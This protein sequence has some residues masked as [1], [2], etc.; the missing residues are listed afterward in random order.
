[1][2]FRKYLGP[3]LLLL[4][5][6]SGASAQYNPWWKWARADTNAALG[7]SG[8]GSILAAK[9]GK[10]LWGYMTANQTVVNASV[11]GTWTIFEYDSNGVR[12]G[13]AA[14]GGKVDL[15]DAQADAAG[16]W[17]VLGRYY[18]S[19]VLPSTTLIRIN[20]ATN[21]DPDHFLLR[22]NAGSMFMS[23]FR[24]I[25]SSNN[26][27]SRA[28]TV[29]NNRIILAA[30]STDATY[31]RSVDLTTGNVTPLFRQGGTSTT[32]SVQA[33]AGGNIYLAGSCSTSDMDFNGTAQPSPRNVPHAYIVKYNASG[34]H[35]W[36][37]WIN[38]PQCAQRK[39]TL[40]KDRFLY[41][42]GTVQDSLMLGPVSVH[43]PHRAL[44]YLSAR[45]DTA[46]NVMWVRQVDTSGN[47]EASL[48]EAAYH[49]VVT[50]DTALVIFA[51]GHTYSDWGDGVMTNLFG[52]YSSVVV[53]RGADGTTRWA[54]AALADNT[55]N[56]H[57]AVD[58]DG[59]YVC[60]SAFSN[61]AF[62]RMDT[63]NLR[64]AARAWTP[65]LSRLRLTQ[66]P[67]VIIKAAINGVSA[68]ALQAY[69]NPARAAVRIAGL[70]GHSE[71]TLRGMSGRVVLQQATDR[72]ETTLDVAELP[73][74]L[75]FLHL[76]GSAGGQVR[77][78]TL[79]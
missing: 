28:F 35:R 67:V 72:P 40:F 33:D 18:D 77:K 71:L 79:Q 2:T 21:P 60:G 31:V 42:T 24:P 6:V 59:V 57:I 16:N 58:G 17:Y 36:H 10:A 25:G 43:R 64:V 44:D 23:W 20:P 41:Y 75:Y 52:S 22:L 66:P 1:M 48:G 53:S 76:N 69:P 62:V 49:A 3:L 39:L 50:P 4:A 46:G 30:D 26:M 51:Q 37:H 38:D 19:I 12:K 47:G 29:D 11:M 63:L 7:F 14:F 32:T 45:L 13:A 56:D 5:C 9:G 8:G 54:R 15:I 27:K 70:S 65:F 61:T 74:G 68:D 78:I 55:T 34:A 73:R